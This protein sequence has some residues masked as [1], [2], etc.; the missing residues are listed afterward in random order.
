VANWPESI[1]GW[2]WA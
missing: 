1:E 2:S